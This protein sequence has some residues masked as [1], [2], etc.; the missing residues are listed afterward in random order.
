MWLVILIAPTPESNPRA[1]FQ[2]SVE[3][4]YYIIGIPIVAIEWELIA[5]TCA[6]QACCCAILLSK[7]IFV[8]ELLNLCISFFLEILLILSNAY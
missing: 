5:S 6:C 4:F 2:P 3:F 8:E 1:L 7:E